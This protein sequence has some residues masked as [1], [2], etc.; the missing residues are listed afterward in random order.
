MKCRKMC[1]KGVMW[2]NPLIIPLIPSYL[3]H[4]SVI[5]NKNCLEDMYVSLFRVDMLV[6]N[7]CSVYPGLKLS[8][9]QPDVYK[10]HVMINPGGIGP[11]RY[12]NYSVIRAS[13]KKW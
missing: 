1:F 3:E 9:M 11:S 8:L 5:S 7:N 10:S 13:G 6:T 4:W 12:H 2:I